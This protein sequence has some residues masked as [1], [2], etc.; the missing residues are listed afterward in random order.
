M[1]CEHDVKPLGFDI[2]AASPNARHWGIRAAKGN[3]QH[4]LSLWRAVK[5]KGWKFEVLDFS[6][7]QQIDNLSAVYGVTS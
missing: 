1:F 4:K 6:C 3:V 7:V 5:P 2:A